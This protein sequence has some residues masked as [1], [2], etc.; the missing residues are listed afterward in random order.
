[1]NPTLELPISQ[2]FIYGQPAEV[3]VLMAVRYNC[4]KI[5]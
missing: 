4:P 1:M 3:T 2:Y 5:S